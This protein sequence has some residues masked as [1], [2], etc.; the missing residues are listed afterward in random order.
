MRQY[1]VAAVPQLEVSSI[2]CYSRSRNL[3][4]PVA[5]Q[6]VFGGSQTASLPSNQWQIEASYW[7]HTSL[8]LL[9]N[10]V[11]EYASGAEDL[12]RTGLIEKP[13]GNSTALLNMCNNQMVRDQGTHQNFSIVGMSL[14]LVLGGLLMFIS[15]V[16]DPVVGFVQHR[17]RKWEYKR[18]AWIND[19]FLHLQQQ[20]YELDRSPIGTRV[21]VNEIPATVGQKGSIKYTE[22]QNLQATGLDTDP[23]MMGYESRSGR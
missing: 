5:A 21:A 8:A 20:V 11:V 22:D 18:T 17:L 13:A 23:F 15:V 14:V 12:G 3:W 2:S 9:Q 10:A 19:A 4:S 16:I 7:F 1:L 6:T